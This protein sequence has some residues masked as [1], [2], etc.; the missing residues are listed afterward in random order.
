M[1]IRH[2]TVADI[3]LIQDLTTIIWPA[4]YSSILSN[5]QIDYML[6]M[7]YSSNALRHQ[8]EVLQHQFLICY[9]GERAIGFASYGQM[10]ERMYKLHK[11]Y[12]LPNQQG[13][14]IGK[15]I[16]DHIEKDLRREQAIALDLNVNRHNPAKLFYER[17]GFI[18]VREEDIDIGN[19]YWMNDYLMR[20]EL[21]Q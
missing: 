20:K 17:L 8:M 7:M 13:K 21:G 19:G 3:P 11:I 2:A 15:F 9:D 18:V 14:G 6:A 12:I 5:E 4:A 1:T 16:I 10:G